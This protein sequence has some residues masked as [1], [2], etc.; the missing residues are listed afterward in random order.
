MSSSSSSVSDGDTIVLDKVTMDINQRSKI[1]LVGKNGCGKRCDDCD[2]D[3]YI[4]DDDDDGGGGDDYIDND[5]DDD[6]DDDDGDDYIDD[7]D[8]DDDGEYDDDDDD[9]IDDRCDKFVLYV[10]LLIVPSTTN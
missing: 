4:D 1:A 7:D 3:D 5:D 2:G 6:D 9:Y 8:D 10:Y